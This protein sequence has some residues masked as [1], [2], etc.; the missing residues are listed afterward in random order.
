MK[1]KAVARIDYNIR[2]NLNSSISKKESD[3][4][5]FFYQCYSTFIQYRLS[6]D[7]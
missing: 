3:K 4:A 6:K 1:Q 2:E 5:V 7:L